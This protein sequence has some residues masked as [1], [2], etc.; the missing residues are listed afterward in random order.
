MKGNEKVD[1]LA[2]KAPVKD[3]LQLHTT[4]NSIFAKTMAKTGRT[5]FHV[6][7]DPY[8]TELDQELESYPYI[9]SRGCKDVWWTCLE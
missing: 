4:A 5:W 3:V 7:V 2:A 8:N 9:H 1:Q 6:P